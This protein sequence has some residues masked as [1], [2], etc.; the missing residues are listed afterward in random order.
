MQN[1]KLSPYQLCVLKVLS[2]SKAPMSWYNIE[3]RLNFDGQREMLPAALA[4]L[5][6]YGFAAM[7]LDP[8]AKIPEHHTITDS[9]LEILNANDE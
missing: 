9:G 8:D 3:Q 2:R 6:K 4:T 5:V 7:V 1:H